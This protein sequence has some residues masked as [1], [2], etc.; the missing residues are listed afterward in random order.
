M[1]PKFIIVIYG[2]DREYYLDIRRDL[3]AQLQAGGLGL[4]DMPLFVS[5]PADYTSVEVVW[6]IEPAEAQR[7]PLMEYLTAEAL[8]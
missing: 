7:K 3:M 5:L 1:K 2:V 4:P 8:Q 6:I